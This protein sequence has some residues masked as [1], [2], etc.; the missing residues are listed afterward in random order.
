MPLSIRLFGA[1][2][3]ALDHQ[4]VRIL[5]KKSRALLY[6]VAG[7]EDPIRREQLISIFWPD[8]PRPSGFQA[9]RTSLYAVRKALGEA[10]VLRHDLVE[11]SGASWVD[12]REFEAALKVQDTDIDRLSQALDLYRGDFL[13]GFTLPETQTFEDWMVVQREHYRRQAIRSLM[14]LSIE[15]ERKAEYQAALAPLERALRLDPLQEDLARE[16]MRLYYLAGDRPGAIRLYDELRKLLDRE[17]GVPPMAETRAL[18]DAIINDADI[19]THANQER[20][21][22]APSFQLPLSINR[23]K[24]DFGSETKPPFVGREREIHEVTSLLDQK[25][26]V[27]LEG[28]PGIGKS[29]LA[30]ELLSTFSGIGLVG[31]ARELEQSLSYHPVIEALRDLFNQEGSRGLLYEVR[32][33]L[34]P[35]WLEEISL[36]LPE[37]GALRNAGSLRQA[38]EARLWEAVRQFLLALA[39]L[40]PVI[41]FLDDLHQA[42]SSTLALLGYLV[43]QTQ[44]AQIQFLATTRP[45]AASSP[46]GRFEQMLVRE[47]RLARVK[48]ERLGNAEIAEFVSR[49]KVKDKDQLVRWLCKNSEGSPYIMVELVRYL[50]REGILLGNTVNF[51]ALSSSPIVPQTVYSLVESRL[52]RLT[53]PARRILDAAV[54]QGRE[55]DFEI[56]TRAAGLS[57]NAAMDALD[58]LQGAELIAPLKF[59]KYVIDHPV[60]MEVAYRD[61][62]ELRHRI[63]HRRVADAIQAVYLNRP[64]AGTFKLN[65]QLARHYAESDQPQRS[66][67]FA[68]AAGDHALRIAAWREAGEFYQ[69]ALTWSSGLGR[70]K[71]LKSLGQAYERAGNFVRASEAL[72]EALQIASESAVEQVERDQIVLRLARSMIPQARYHEIID[73]VKGFL[74]SENPSAIVEAELLWGT[75]LSLEG[76]ELESARQHLEAAAARW[77]KHE[78]ED[79]SIIAQ[80][81]F[82]IGSVAAQLGELEDAVTHYRRSLELTKGANLGHGL[83]Q[84]ILAYNNL[85]YHLHLL[86]DPAA[87]EYAQAGIALAQERGMVGLQTY[88]YSTL[89]EIALSE[90]DYDQAEKLFQKGLELAK[91]FSIPEREAGLMANLG[92]VA[93]GRGEN[94]LAVYRLS[95]ALGKAENLG[96]QHLAIQIRLWLAPLL[97]RPEAHMHLSEAR[98]MA[99]ASS[100]RKLLSDLERVEQELK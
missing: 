2:E 76:A 66:L 22:G 18:Y 8:L 84:Q 11:L 65:A 68:I 16:A 67:E 82:E 40:T 26:L 62:G 12:V 56:V 34:A 74:S 72:H 33:E 57:E 58:E 95:N 59:G 17:M 42:D 27:M 64:E 49:L 30:E 46:A 24:P 92:L 3:F 37:I 43:R 87:R 44:D 83:N 71:V 48:L 91:Q 60:T 99:K 35:V 47:G 61:V 54:A 9:L 1:P 29:R 97:P 79:N 75:A 45:F 69:T 14:T 89:G 70:L 4:Q 21:E 85:A 80:I 73:L 20:L 23:P 55:F 63:F 88:L 32:R 10:I 52:S 98:R 25:Y 19:P 100:R 94:T 50:R 15:Y 7:N 28:E 6:F 90:G 81:E 53:E 41:F 86:G 5:R 13:Q 36:L 78:W 38:D 51:E 77:E 39:R 96:V 31:R 93:A